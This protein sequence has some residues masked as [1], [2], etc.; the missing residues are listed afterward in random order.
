MCRS[1]IAITPLQIR[2]DAHG[3]HPL[4]CAAALADFL[5]NAGV[6]NKKT[7]LSFREVMRRDDQAHDEHA[8][9]SNMSVRRN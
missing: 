7:S 4:W 2:C 5:N 8:H 6:E 1:L 9:L 3:I